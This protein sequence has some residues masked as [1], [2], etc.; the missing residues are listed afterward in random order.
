YNGLVPGPTVVATSGTPQLVR[1]FNDLPDV[2]PV[3]IGE[4]ITAVHRHGGFQGP[5]DDGYPLDTFARRRSRD[6][7]Y[8]N[9]PDGGLEQNEHSTTWY[10]DHTIDI[11][12]PNVYRGLAGFYL[13]FDAVDSIAGELDTNP[14]ALRL[15]GRMVSLPS[16]EQFREFDVPIVIQDK[17]FDR[18]GFLVFDT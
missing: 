1:F 8:P 4:P 2:D 3:G 15:P 6:Y 9:R 16:G 13:S 7:F 5:A 18:N 17:L 10:H 11:T 14:Q 12:G